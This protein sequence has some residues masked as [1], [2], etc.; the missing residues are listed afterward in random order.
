V[1]R[2]RAPV[3]ARIAALRMLA[4]RE[5]GRTELAQRLA[6]RGLP[7]DEIATA[8]DDLERLGLL[9]DSRYAHA[10]VAQMTGRYARRA[11]VYTMRER[12]VASDAVADVDAELGAIDDET[13]AR[14][15]LVR[16]FPDPPANDRELARQV[17]F[18]QA[19][20]YGLSLILRIVRE[21]PRAG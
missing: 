13:D 14:A 7:A 11:I 10:L 19:R 9:S 21:R 16:R 18:L 6:R 17:R 15:M 2:V 3:S 4:R 1:K 5:Y 20:G 12:G 8:L